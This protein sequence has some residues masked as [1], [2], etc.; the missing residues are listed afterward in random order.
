MVAEAERVRELELLVGRGSS[1]DG[2]ARWKRRSQIFGRRRGGGSVLVTA[3][4]LTIGGMLVS[5]SD[6]S[7]F[8]GAWSAGA[9]KSPILRSFGVASASSAMAQRG[10]EPCRREVGRADAVLRLR[11]GKAFLCFGGDSA[12]G[13]GAKSFLK[14]F[15][16]L[17]RGGC[18]LKEGW[19]LRRCWLGP[20]PYWRRVYVTVGNDGFLNYNA[21]VR[22][23]Y[24]PC[25]G[26]VPLQGCSVEVENSPLDISGACLSL[27]NV[28]RV[29][30][31]AQGRAQGRGWWLGDFLFTPVGTESTVEEWFAAVSAAS[32]TPCT[33]MMLKD[34][35]M[36]GVY[37]WI[38]R[39]LVNIRGK[40][41]PGVDADHIRRRFS[42][43]LIDGMALSKLTSDDL[44]EMGIHRIGVRAHILESIRIASTRGA[45]LGIRTKQQTPQ[46]VML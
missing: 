2:D 42:E 10:S 34:L 26:S 19:I 11:G 17:D 12:E 14:S 28:I 30:V 7:F 41:G 46:Q 37:R 3:M 44:R 32:N 31:S 36:Q 4:A 13:E 38:G 45:D 24:M 39:E 9:P 23:H 6:A 25:D 15:L 27:G 40:L 21:E 43:N 20:F 33:M 1:L 18:T 8:Q 35:D 16:D 22:Q 29:R 5:A